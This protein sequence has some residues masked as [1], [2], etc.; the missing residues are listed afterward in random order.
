VHRKVYV[1]GRQLSDDEIDEKLKELR[2][3]GMGRLAHV[4]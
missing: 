3:E 4:E 2:I 1:N